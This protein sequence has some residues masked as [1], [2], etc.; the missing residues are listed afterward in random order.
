MSDWRVVYK[1]QDIPVDGSRRVATPMGDIAVC[2]TADDRI[3]A[4]GGA[5]EEGQPCALAGD[6]GADAVRQFDVHVSDGVILLN[7]A[8]MGLTR[9]AT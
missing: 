8:G 1:L 7:M 9:L 4:V 3:I 5:A 6:G 2:R